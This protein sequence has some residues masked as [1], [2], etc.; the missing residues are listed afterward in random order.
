MQDLLQ[1]N[2][3]KEK[4]SCQTWPEV[5]LSKTSK[6]DLETLKTFLPFWIGYTHLSV[7]SGS[8]LFVGFFRPK[9]VGKNMGSRNGTG[10]SPAKRSSNVRITFALISSTALCWCHSEQLRQSFVLAMG[11][12]V[13]WARG[14]GIWK[15]WVKGKGEKSPKQLGGETSHRE[16]FGMMIWWLFFGVRGTIASWKENKHSQLFPVIFCDTFW[17]KPNNSFKTDD[18]ALQVMIIH[19]IAVF[20]LNIILQNRWLDRSGG[21]DIYIYM[22]IHIFFLILGWMLNQWLSKDFCSISQVERGWQFGGCW[23]QP[24]D[25]WA[26]TFRDTENPRN[27]SLSGWW[28][29]KYLLS[30][31]PL[32]IGE[33]IP[34]CLVQPPTSSEFTSTEITSTWKTSCC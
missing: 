21:D 7:R 29:L 33:K 34:F 10:T 27:F 24:I 31:S 11:A 25:D 1:Q 28:Q 32:K 20:F 5:L 3:P 19:Q 6:K 26:S 17:G 13:G 23:F 8:Y 18:F 12:G 30:F 15:R 2:L 22:Y 4:K 16:G 14:F 9:N